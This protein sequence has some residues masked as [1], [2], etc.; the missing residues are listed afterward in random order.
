MERIEKG[1]YYS[2]LKSI[3]PIRLDLEEILDING[4]NYLNLEFDI[5]NYSRGVYQINVITKEHYLNK[6]KSRII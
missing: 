1:R 2:H 3:F 6:T 5:S 4:S